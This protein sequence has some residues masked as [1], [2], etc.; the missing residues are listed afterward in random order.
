MKLLFDQ[1]L[2]RK[3]VDR[4]HD[5]FPDSSHVTAVGL[6]TAT[7]HEVWD[8]ARA[9]GYAIASK[10]SDFRQ[11][12]FL[13]GPPPKVIW[14]RVGNASTAHVLQVIADHVEDI[15][16]FDRS[17]DAALLVIPRLPN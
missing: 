9:H 14:L 6:D 7:D 5:V 10:D 17:E 11:L 3:L 1:N 15:R 16:S 13:Y 12:A 4:L 8:F 2:S